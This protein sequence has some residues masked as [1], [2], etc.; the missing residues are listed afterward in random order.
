MLLA[1]VK[2][3]VVLLLIYISIICNLGDDFVSK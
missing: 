1:K 3:S 2:C